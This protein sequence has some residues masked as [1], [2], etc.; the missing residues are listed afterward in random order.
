MSRNRNF[1]FTINNY[2]D[3]DRE[4]IRNIE[5][6]WV[7]AVDEICPTTGTPHLQ[8]S[9]VMANA[10]SRRTL[11]RLLPRANIRV[12]G[13][14]P[15]EN[16]AYCCKTRPIDLVPNDPALIYERGTCPLNQAQKG[17]IAK[18]Q[19]ES[20]C[21]AVAS[22]NIES[23]PESYA[24][25]LK[26]LEYFV[27][28]KRKV[29]EDLPDGYKALWIWGPTGVGKSHHVRARVPK[30]AEKKGNSKWF[31]V[32][33]NGTDE[34]LIDEVA[35]GKIAPEDM[36][37]WTDRYVFPIETKGGE[38]NVR[39]K[40]VFITSQYRIRACYPEEIDYT[41]IERR[42]T[43]VHRTSRDDPADYLPP[44]TGA[45]GNGD[46]RGANLEPIPSNRDGG[47]GD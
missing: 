5:C 29:L 19:W 27:S 8:C 28:K 40:F 9:I 38:Q 30:P 25:R 46:E 10:V 45:P 21:E 23:L 31:P 43:E 32:K 44:I 16:R 47:A 22:G 1:L 7:I 6:P 39:P 14:T 18:R 15:Q 3:A 24:M 36:K 42:C 17:A 37:A 2:T 20:A 33:W 12:M 11:S 13:G 41:A 4:D 26:Q 35:P 34:L